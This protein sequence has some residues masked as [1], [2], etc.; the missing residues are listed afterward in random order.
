MAVAY[1]LSLQVFPFPLQNPFIKNLSQSVQHFMN[2]MLPGLLLGIFFVGLLSHIP[3]KFVLS[4]F[5]NKRGWGS[6]LRA[7]CAGVLLDVCSHGI[8]LVGIQLYKKGLSL[9]Q[10]MA[11]LIASPWNSI[12]LTLVLVFLIG[13]KWTLLFILGSMLI[14]LVTGRLFDFFV[15]KKVLPENPN[16]MDLPRDFHFRRELK[17]DLQLIPWSW[18][19]PGKLLYSG[20]KESKML[21]KWIFFGVLLASFISA[22]LPPEQYP[23]LLG[24]TPLGMLLVLLGATILEVCSEGSSPI[25][26]D[27]VTKAHAPG[28]G[29]VFLMAGVA[30]DYTEIISIKEGTQSWKVAFFLP[31][32]TVPQTLGIGLI[33]NYFS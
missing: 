29:F 18:S 2:R 7:T 25:A 16:K 14:A 5:G 8:L 23:A 15:D 9:G 21:L 19:L 6:L 31:L 4:L 3:Q 24:K 28:N 17:K 32:L 10:T 1:L 33:L 22:V 26:A 27:I 20:L 11:F 30:T 12:S 13:L